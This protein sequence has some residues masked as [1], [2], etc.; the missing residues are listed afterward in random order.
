LVVGALG[1]VYG[2][3]G[4][5]PLYALRE[6]FLH[7]LPANRAN[8][9]GALSLITWTLIALVSVKYLSFVMRADNRGE[10]GILAMMTLVTRV[11]DGSGG[12][13]RLLVALGVLGACLLYADA[14]IT[15]A[16]TVLSAIEGLN[17]AT[18]VLQPYIVPL[19]I[20]ILLG[21]FAFQHHGTARIGT[22]F[23]PLMLLWFVLIGL[24]GVRSIVMTPSVLLAL[25]PHYGVAFLVGHGW[26]GLAILGSVFLAV[27]G[28]EVLYA[29]M[30]H[31]GRRPIWMGWFYLVFPSLLL[32]YYG[33]GAFLFRSPGVVE[34]LFYRAAPGWAL[35]PM[36]L[37][38][39]MASVVASQAVI[40]GAFSISR[41]AMQLGYCPRLQTQQTSESVIGQIY[42]P[43]ANWMLLV[44]TLVLVLGF[45]HSSDLAAA[46]GIAVSTAMLVT[47]VLLYIVARRV[48]G[49]PRWTAGL[50]AGMFLIPDG[51]FFAAN[52]MKV[53]SGG[54]LPLLVAA[55]I[56]LLMV[57]WRDGRDRLARSFRQDALPV[58]QFLA[59]I[60][61]HP[62]LRV[63][64]LGVFLS[65]N[66]T[67]VPRTL[68]HNLKHNCVLHEKV[69]LLT[70]RT[71]EVPYVPASERAHV[72]ELGN[73][74]FR[75]SLAYGFSETPD[76]PA[77][78]RRTGGQHFRYDPMRTT[79][80]LGRETL[81][82]PKGRVTAARRWQT[83][84]F[85]FMCRNALDPTKF[86]RLPPNRVVELGI[87]VQL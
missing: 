76:V 47:T 43:S 42:V 25:S 53:G 70:V 68:L 59:D 48:W 86:F 81:L 57:T 79:F 19:A 87:Q 11:V 69:I 71:E 28:A 1:V 73:G 40:S 2:D 52:L 50:M 80:F 54:W 21:L 3:I 18:P 14:M 64:G 31:F 39:T 56:Y 36:V 29:D 74:M 17:V 15:P 85:T 67:G 46:Y 83:S 75:V 66:P 9:L 77:A 10:G 78:L 6:C 5:S 8:V 4:T 37:V 12:V 84:V 51:G 72:D 16:I 60:A 35:Y 22:V 7:G 26:H 45:R 33:Q 24:V 32:C 55:L 23:G 49:W 27:T 58:D 38:A 63:P 44:A 34:D 41:Q 61:R 20:C 65:G 13:H 30:G 82:D 62:P